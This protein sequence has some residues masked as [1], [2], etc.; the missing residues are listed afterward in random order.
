M[1]NQLAIKF[2]QYWETFLDKTPQIVFA[3]LILIIFYFAGH[4]LKLIYKKKIAIR[5]KDSIISNF[6]GQAIKFLFVLFGVLAALHSIGFGGFA[7]SLLAG[8][9]I[10]AIIVGFAFKDIAENFLAGI[11]LAVNRPFKIGD[12]IEVDNYKG[13]VRNLELRSTHLRVVDGRDI[14][15]PNA[16]MVK[17]PLTNYTQDG[18]L[19]IDFQIGLDTESN[20]FKA[21]ELILESFKGDGE[22][23]QKPVPDV[24]IANFS[25]SS[26]DIRVLFWT[27]ILEMKSQ[28]PDTLGGPLR[29]RIMESTK[30]LLLSSGFTLPSNL[31][32]HRIYQKDNPI[33]IKVINSGKSEETK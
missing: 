33:P 28:K 26:M 19:R 29:S 32:E 2:E 22:I 14:Y 10:S 11:L 3:L 25:A 12:I 18:L 4:L 9:G 16:Q 21:R 20:F 13:T 5:W 24:H 30:A 7:S 1:F 27:D 8:A 6:I 17:S 31:L 23:L 15:V